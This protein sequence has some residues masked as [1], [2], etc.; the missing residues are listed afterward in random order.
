MGCAKAFL[1]FK[2]CRPF[3]LTFL[4][5]DVLGPPRNIHAE[6]SGL[7]SIKVTWDPVLA[8]PNS[9]VAYTVCL[10][11][12]RQSWIWRAYNRPSGVNFNQIHLTN[13]Q[14]NTHVAI[15]ASVTSNGGAEYI[16]SAKITREFNIWKYFATFY[17]SPPLSWIFHTCSHPASQ[18][19]SKLV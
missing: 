13:S 7:N 12:N 6:Q 16:S 18:D 9:T 15:T 8:S 14:N 4:D 17:P 5:S 10:E 3:G 19:K 11:Y 1:T 2:L